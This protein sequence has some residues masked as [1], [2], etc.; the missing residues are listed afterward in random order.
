[1][2]LLRPAGGELR[3]GTKSDLEFVV[4]GFHLEQQRVEL[5]QSI[6]NDHLH[7]FVGDS[8]RAWVAATRRAES[9]R[10]DDLIST[11][12]LRTGG[13]LRPLLSRDFLSL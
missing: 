1:M 10:V 7:L 2:I 8:R 5:V 3:A 4:C 9:P 12:P 6:L 11:G 13:L